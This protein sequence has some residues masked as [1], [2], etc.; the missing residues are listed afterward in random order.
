MECSQGLVQSM[1]VALEIK[2]ETGCGDDVEIE[3]LK[4]ESA[5]LTQL[6]HA[7]TYTRQ[8][9]LGQ[10]DEYRSRGMDL[11]AAEAG[12]T[13]SHGDREIQPHHR[14]A[15]FRSAAD[16]PD[17]T[18]TPEVLNEPLRSVGLRI[19]GMNLQR[20]QQLAHAH[21]WLR[22]AI[23]SAVETAEDPVAAASSMDFSA[24]RSMARKLPRLISK[25]ASWA[26]LSTGFV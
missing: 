18:G 4:R 1:L 12:G 10:I 22:A 6:G 14:L 23:T 26:S 24:S 15:G 25:M 8:R 13:G 17:S 9:V 19:D 21:N 3:V 2:A 5:V 20:R 11:E 7:V 16:Y